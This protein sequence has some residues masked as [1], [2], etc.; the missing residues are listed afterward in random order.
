MSDNNMAIAHF[1]KYDIDKLKVYQHNYLRNMMSDIASD[2]IDT[3]E[4]RRSF[5]ET[6][7]FIT[8]IE[9][10]VEKSENDK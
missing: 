7:I 2:K 10:E 6:A 4:L 3:D 9:S 8:F 1:T 5:I